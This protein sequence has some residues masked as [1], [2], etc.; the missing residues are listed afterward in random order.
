[1]DWLLKNL[2]FNT[3]YQYI[4]ISNLIMKQINVN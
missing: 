3:N 2:E 1:M 4:K